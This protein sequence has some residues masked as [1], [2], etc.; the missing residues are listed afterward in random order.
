MKLTS[1]AE[2]I[3]DKMRKTSQNTDFDMRKYLGID[4]ALQSIQVEMVNNT[5]NLT[6]IDKRVRKVAES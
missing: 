6:E 5:S 2:D 4:K 1:L 3:H